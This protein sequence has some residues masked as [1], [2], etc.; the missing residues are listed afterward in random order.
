MSNR[1]TYR[2]LFRRVLTSGG[3]RLPSGGLI[4]KAVA[5]ELVDTIGL[6]ITDA[7]LIREEF[8]PLFFALDGE[9]QPVSVLDAATIIA[10]IEASEYLNNGWELGGSTTTGYFLYAIGTLSAILIRAYRWAG[11]TFPLVVAYQEDGTAWL[12]ENGTQV[13]QEGVSA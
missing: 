8:W 2:N 9:G 5:P 7:L 11:E 12:Q 6:L 1:K 3:L 4:F 10:N 13:Y